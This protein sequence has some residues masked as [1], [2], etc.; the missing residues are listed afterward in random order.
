[1]RTLP[2]VNHIMLLEEILVDLET[3]GFARGIEEYSVTVFGAPSEDERGGCGSK[4][5]T[6][7]STSP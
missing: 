3:D 7:R 6:S 1:M 5:T 4:G 2:Q